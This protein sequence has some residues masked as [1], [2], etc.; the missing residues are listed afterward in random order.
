MD[1][2]RRAEETR[3]HTSFLSEKRSPVARRSLGSGARSGMPF[4]FERERVTMRGSGGVGGGGRP[5]GTK[6]T[7][8][9]IVRG[10]HAGKTRI[11]IRIQEYRKKLRTKSSKR[12]KSNTGQSQCFI[13]AANC[14]RKIR[15]QSRQTWS[16]PLLSI[17]NCAH[18][19]ICF[20]VVNPTAAE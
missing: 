1:T 14:F 4:T 18:L 20:A 3:Y 9:Q 16:F 17:V 8:K 19:K 10:A 13:V 5:G 7:S 15:S 2:R 12:K 6:G 11:F